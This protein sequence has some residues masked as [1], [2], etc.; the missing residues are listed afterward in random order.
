MVISA[1]RGYGAARLLARFGISLF[2]LIKVTSPFLLFS[3]FIGVAAAQKPTIRTQSNVVLVPVLVRDEKH[4]VLYG[5]QADDFIIEDDG[6]EQ[7]VHLDEEAEFDPVS[8]VIAIQTGRRASY[9][10]P[11]MRTLSTMLDPILSRGQVQVAVVRFD[12]HV[13]I[14]RDF[15]SDPD[16]I[17]RALNNLQGGDHGAAILDVVDYS[18]KLLKKIPQTRQRVLLLISETRD[19]GSHLVNLDD[20]ITSIGES[21]TVVYTLTFSPSVSN[22]LDTMRGTNKSEMRATVDLFAVLALARQAMRQNTARAVA[23]MTGGGYQQFTSLK[24]FEKGMDDLSND[25]HGRYL[26]SFE[27]QNPHPGRHQI[28][29][30]LKKPGNATISARTTYW[31]PASLR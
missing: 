8:L 20:L 14:V 24:S 31:A 3:L 29:V 30:R 2:T 9:E 13:E 7:A 26:L 15:T 27:P 1:N 28:R 19:H 25:L 22:V 11:R 12:S 10:F 17:Q 16:L 21:D 5:L 18:V 23:M 6:V 4:A